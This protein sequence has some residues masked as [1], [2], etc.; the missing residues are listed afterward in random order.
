METN[1]ALA[2]LIAKHPVRLA[3]ELGYDLLREGLHDRWIH[4]MV[5]GTGDMTLQS[6]RG[7]YKTTCVEVA[8]WLILLTRPDLTVGFQRKG[9]ND[10]AEVLA[11]VKRMVEH[12]LTQEIAQSIYLSL[13][14]ISEPT[15]PY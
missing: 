7:S 9:E 2:T 8:L 14:H 10:V 6:H 13:I 11:A 1:R 4:E 15:R 12:P 3:H 5:F